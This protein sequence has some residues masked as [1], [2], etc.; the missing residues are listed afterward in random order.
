MPTS[1]QLSYDIVPDKSPLHPGPSPV[2][3]LAGRW[4]I[5]HPV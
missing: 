3:D 1:V 2:R 5:S 4:A